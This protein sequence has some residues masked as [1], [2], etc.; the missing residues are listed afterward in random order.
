MCIR[1]SVSI[2]V[3]PNPVASISGDDAVCEGQ[4]TVFTADGGVTYNW[5]SGANTI[6]ITVTD[7]SPQF[8]TV[9]DINGCTATA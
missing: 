3:F 1:D 6:S 7:N 2:T 5:G 8:V 9:T 4:T